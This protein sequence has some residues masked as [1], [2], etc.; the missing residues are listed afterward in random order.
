MWISKKKY[1]EL[2]KERNLYKATVDQYNEQYDRVRD[3]INQNCETIEDLLDANGRMSAQVDDYH[4]T[5]KDAL[6]MLDNVINI[7]FE[8]NRGFEMVVFQK[9]GCA[10]Q[11]Y[12]KGKLVKVKMRDQ[13]KLVFYNGGAGL[14]KTENI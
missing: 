2:V 9:Y 5:L 3:A 4:D 12:H 8:G 7:T 10:P 14:Q 13:M 11:I 1:E 6:D